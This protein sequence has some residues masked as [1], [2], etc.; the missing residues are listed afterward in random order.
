[1]SPNRACTVKLERPRSDRYPGSPLPEI[2]QAITSALQKYFTEQNSG[3]FDRDDPVKFDHDGL[4]TLVSRIEV[5]RTQLVMSLKPIDRS[6][7]AAT[8]SVPWQKPPS[9][10]FR[11]IL[12]PNGALREH[13]RP[14][15]AER[16]LRLIGAIAQG[17]RWLDEIIAGSITD[18]EQLAKREGCTQRQI[19]LTLSLA[20]PAPLLV[21]AAVEGRLRRGINIERLRD[22]DPNLDQAIPG[23]LPRSE[24]DR[25]EAEP[26]ASSRLTL[27]GKS[28]PLFNQ[29]RSE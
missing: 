9:K 20:F 27:R 3:T 8:L 6:T 12:L 14:D 22:P 24:L 17:R 13:I 4:A 10:R 19:N 5:Q 1:M 15:R 11:K 16:R 21:K 23:S 26:A 18:A 7:E 28:P 2:A 25:T 29:D